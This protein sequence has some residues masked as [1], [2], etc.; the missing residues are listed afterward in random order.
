[1]LGQSYFQLLSPLIFLVF[2]GGFLLLWHYARSLRSLRCFAV[3]YFLAASAMIGDFLRIAMDPDLA[4]GLITVLYLAATVFFCA[5]LYQLY[6]SRVPWVLLT[7]TAVAVFGVFSLALYGSRSLTFS[8]W[9]LN[10][11]IVS[12]YLGSIF[13]LRRDMREGIHRVLRIVVSVSAYLLLVR[14]AMVFGFGAAMTKANYA[15]SIAAM[16]L[17]LFIAVTA[18]VVAG[19]LFVMYGMEIVR[20][21]T[22]T[23]ETDPLTGVLNRRGLENRLSSIID[24]GPVGEIGYAVVMA[25]IDR[26]KTVNDTHGHDAGDVIITAFADLLGEVAR[27]CDCVARWGGE[28]FLIVISNAESAS[29][30][31]YAETVR[32][33]WES[34]RH[35]CLDGGT[36]T[37][38]FGFTSW[39][40]G[41]DL[42]GV[43]RQADAALYR[44]KREGRNRV[45]A[46]EPEALPGSFA[47]V[48]A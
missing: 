27:E 11:G 16:T 5:G 43:S 34:L 44:A 20:R 47:A 33:R 45:C 8:A 32:A 17:Q 4:S 14:T 25:D 7:V 19:V 42:S 31:L 9:A 36:V 18:L 3:S 23:S 21:L 22:R 48:V 6:R 41:Q 26:F 24:D 30:R 35:D 38:S 39:R 1:M 12:L 10:S 2:S 46:Y 15:G 29:A 40:N 37:A 13:A 28:E